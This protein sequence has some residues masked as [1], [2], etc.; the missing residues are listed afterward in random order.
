MIAKNLLDLLSKFTKGLIQTNNQMQN[1]SFYSR[2]SLQ[3]FIL[4]CLLTSCAPKRNLVYLGDTGEKL[5]SRNYIALEP[6]ILPND[7]LS[8]SVSTLSAESNTLFNGNTQNNGQLHPG[9]RVDG[10][11]FI[12]FPGLKQMKLRDLTLSEAKLKLTKALADL[13][14]DPNVSISFMNFRI[15]VI[16]EVSRPGTF[17][18]ANNEVT[19]LEALGLAGDMTAY[20]RRDNVK[21]IRQRDGVREIRN[22]NINSVEV[23]NSDFYYLMQND[24][25]YVEPDKSKEQSINQ[26]N[27]YIPIISA[28]LSVLAVLVSVLIRR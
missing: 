7:L 14:K 23:L 10:N 15:T 21:V 19:L 8:I 6:R 2:F 11:G 27:K 26:N 24:I 4:L 5:S 22:L 9:Y 18:I 3:A 13:T 20:G 28:S 25:V 1:I 17:T 12:N 16:G